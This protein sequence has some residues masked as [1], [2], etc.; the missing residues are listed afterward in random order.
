MTGKKKWI[1][2]VGVQKLVSLLPFSNAVNFRLQRHFGGLRSSHIASRHATIVRR[3]SKL[4]E[5][6]NRHE[7]RLRAAAVVEIGTGWDLF[8]ALL[9]STYEPA[10]IVTIDTRRHVRGPLFR[11]A[12]ETL[13]RDGD[14][15]PRFA[16]DGPT[17]PLTREESKLPYPD[18]LARRGIRYEAP[19]DARRTGLSDASIDVVY[20]I[21]VLE[22]VPA[23]E[24]GAMLDECRRILKPGGV[25]FHHIQPYDHASQYGASPIEFLR[26]SPFF[27]RTFVNNPLAFQNRLR[28]SQYRALFEEREFEVLWHQR[29]IDADALKQLQSMTVAEEFAGFDPEDLATTY[30]WYLCRATDP[31]GGS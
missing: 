3:V 2:K 9:L 17:R 20:S 23:P 12:A 4:I 6:L 25:M 18:C 1:L 22:H 27:W 16:L 8:S 13:A 26:Y 10:G 15:L 19:G 30:C 11:L 5:T 7:L 21:A 31:G 29:D 14:D 24:L 28:D